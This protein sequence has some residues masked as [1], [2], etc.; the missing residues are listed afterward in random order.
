[1]VWL[2][3]A[4]ILLAVFHIGLTLFNLVGWAFKKLRRIHLVTIALT[5]GSWVILGFFYGFGYC[6]LT[7]WHWEIKRQLGVQK[8][9]NSFIKY[10]LDILF[11]ADISPGVVDAIAVTGLVFALVMTVLKNRDVFKVKRK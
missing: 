10:Y 4:N 3:I 11:D 7:D 8:L 9:P 2:K 5:L 1:M 6:F